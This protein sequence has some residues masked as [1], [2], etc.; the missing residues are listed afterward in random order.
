MNL[1]ENNTSLV[2]AGAWNPAILNPHWVASKAMGLELGQNFQV[3]VE[4]P[5]GAPEQAMKY[6]FEQIKYLAT[7]N[8]LTFYLVDNN[9][10]QKAKSISTAAKILELLSHT[11]VTGFGFNFRYEIENPSEDILDTFVSGEKVAGYFDDVDVDI[12]RHA[13]EVA[14][15]IQDRLITMNVQLEGGR[16]FVTYNV[17]FEVDG[18]VTASQKLNTEG[19]LQTIQNDINSINAKFSPE[20]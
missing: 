19:L 20:E 15:K 6:E 3:I 10:A 18:A 16:V 14:L 5:V 13:W 2:I 8:N 4:V 11:P 1:V 12:A 17:H 7:R 9:D